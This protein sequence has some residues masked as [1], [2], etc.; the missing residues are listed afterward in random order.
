MR[1][2]I[3]LLVVG[4]VM[5]ANHSFAAQPNGGAPQPQLPP[6]G[7]PTDEPL[8]PIPS[9]C[10]VERTLNLG[11]VSRAYTNYALDVATC[12]YTQTSFDVTD[13][14][15][16]QGCK[17]LVVSHGF[18]VN[19][20]W[21]CEPYSNLPGHIEVTI[22]CPLPAA[23]SGTQSFRALYD[24]TDAELDRLQCRALNDCIRNSVSDPRDNI[25]A[26]QWLHKLSCGN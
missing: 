11:V 22:G 24:L 26:H 2:K 7:S 14:Q 18:S 6:I 15:M 23:Q 13:A 8:S 10:R 1:I 3:V 9:I 17:S 16:L 20:Q 12:R 25:L 19:G 21:R 5:M 4:F